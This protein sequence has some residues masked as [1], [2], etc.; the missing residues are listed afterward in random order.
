MS[1]GKE[2]EDGGGFGGVGVAAGGEEE[3][4]AGE[5]EIADGGFAAEVKEV[6]EDFGLFGSEELG[7]GD[8]GADVGE[9]VVGLGVFE[10][11]GA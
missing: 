5:D 10:L 2:R 3:G 1:S 6:V 7:E 9:G 8:E 4:L 11:V